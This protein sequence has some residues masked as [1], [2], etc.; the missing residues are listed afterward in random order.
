MLDYTLLSI[1]NNPTLKSPKFL[2]LFEDSSPQPNPDFHLPSCQIDSSYYDTHSFTSKYTNTTFPIIASINIQSI[3]SKH[4]KLK[5]LL[6]ETQKTPIQIIALQETWSIKHTDLIH[7]PNFN[8][9]HK[10]RPAGNG[11][12]IGFYVKSDLNFK[13]LEKHSKFIPKIFECLTIEVSLNNT[14]TTFSSIYRSPSPSSEHLAEFISNLDTLLHNI[15]SEYQS[16]YI[17]LDSNINTLNISSQHPHFTYLSTIHANGF[18]Q[19]IDRATRIQDTT[20]TLID[21]ILTN[22]NT[23]HIICGTLICD[24]SDHFL[25]FIQLS[26]KHHTSQPKA[27]L[28]RN[29]SDK[30]IQSF[31]LG[32]G[33]LNWTDVLNC[34]N[35][36]T[37]YDM[38]WDNFNTLYEL[39]FPKIKSCFNKN[40][41]KI[42]NFMTNG[43]LVSRTTKIKLHKISIQHPTQ[44]NIS[45]Y[46]KYRNTFNSLIRASKKLYYE[47]NLSK[48]KKDPKKTWALLKE[49]MNLN[50][51][52]EKIE[53]NGTT[54]TNKIEIATHFN[55]HFAR[56][57]QL[58]ADNIPPSS[59]SP[60]SY[61]EPCR[62]P[63]LSL[64]H[65]SQG[66]VANV[67]QAFQPKA[68][69][70]IDGISIKLLK[71]VAIEISTPLAHVFRLS[72]EQGIFPDRLK[73]SRIVPIHKA[74]S[75]ASCDNYRPIALLSS[76][77]K[78]LE[79]IVAT[80]LVNHLETNKLINKNQYGFQRGRNT[81][82]N[83][84]QLINYISK[85]LN[86]GDY[87]IG[88]F[89]DLRK[90]FDVCSHEVLLGKLKH[91]G[92]SNG[93][94]KWFKSYLSD[95]IQQVDIE[96][97][98]SDSQQINISVLQGSILGPILFL[99]YI[100]DLPSA[101]ALNTGLFADDT[102]GL[103]R[104]KNL[105]QL[106]DYVNAELKKWAAWFRAN[107]LAV[108]ASKT[109]YIIFHTKGKKV[110]MNGK[111]IIFDNNDPGYPHDP[112]L[113]I[114]L[115]RIH[116][117]H[118]SPD[119]RNYKLLGIHLDENLT[120]NH[121]TTTLSNK[122]TRSIYCINRVK[123]ILP[124]KALVSLYHALVHSHLLYCPIITNCTSKSNTEKIA[125]LQ[126]KA[127]R[128]VTNSNYTA[129]TEPIFKQLHILPYHKIVTQA[130]LHF[131]HSYHYKYAP[132]AFNNTWILNSERDTPYELRN[133]EDYEIPR[134]NYTSL[135]RFPLYTLPTAWNAAGP[136]KYHS[137]KF[138]FQTALKDELHDA[139]PSSIPPQPFLPPSP[140]PLPPSPPPLPH[141]PPPLPHSPPP[142]P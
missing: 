78:I 111:Q 73:K 40:L 14:K 122:L 8:F 116:N 114:P 37:C 1:N 50:S 26:H 109:K 125:K 70:D 134:L 84:I 72:L 69:T 113:E 24:V 27:Q 12:G 62:A 118:P 94:L 31:K 59:R 97:N 58:I 115:E 64:D 65:V 83:L 135:K 132:A 104:G 71:K 7:I 56:A 30:N 101:S 28:T 55:I 138:T 82:Q 100:N 121:H 87:C 63:E 44:A 51:A 53:I 85:S 3:Q 103:A 36:N 29:F 106:I 142:P 107:K 80:R 91:L 81:E 68:S 88:V 96:G 23:N 141:S 79:K 15:S 92:L 105:P 67:I 38:F 130:Q 66:E 17:C 48:A 43:L 42:C 9:T 25:T 140:S 110:D 108:N 77:S 131:M 119:S 47:S 22:T 11:G 35:V 41:H 20:H 18:I 75:R 90:A 133:S 49:A 5:Q 39:N 32:L 16:S 45:K 117:T 10:Q 95:R 123:N 19:C 112:T 137:N 46:K 54:L 57:G 6:N 34:N 99:C 4:T 129:H 124:Q 126:K 93:A 2:S 128:T 60:E 33:T 13:I 21:H 120:F 89:L 74:G 102:Q 52:S 127:I 61:L 98:L 136:S 139:P 76:I 86:E